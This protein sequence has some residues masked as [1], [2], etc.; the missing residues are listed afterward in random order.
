MYNEMRNILHCEHCDYKAY[1][2]GNMRAHA[3]MHGGN[4]LHCGHC[5]YK[6]CRPGDL[7]RHFLK[8]RG[9]ILYCKHCDKTYLPAEMKIHYLKH[10]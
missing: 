3:L 1:N 4:M 2:P 9:N 7:K 6:T 8:Y 10:G 5:D